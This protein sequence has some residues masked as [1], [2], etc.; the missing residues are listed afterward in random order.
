[1]RAVALAL[2]LSLLLAG[3]YS[4]G[5]PPEDGYYRGT[6]WPGYTGDYR[7]G[8]GVQSGGR[9]PGNTGRK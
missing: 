9:Q 3:C 4:T 7:R 6:G 8:G 5:A 2:L 1:M